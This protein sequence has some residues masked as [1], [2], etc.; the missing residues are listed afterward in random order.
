MKNCEYDHALTFP[1]NQV[2]IINDID[3]R[4]KLIQI[5]GEQ[6]ENIDIFLTYF[7]VFYRYKLF[8]KFFFNPK[9]TEILIKT[10]T[11]NRELFNNFTTSV[12]TPQLIIEDVSINELTNLMSFLIL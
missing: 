9:Y 3:I 1:K 2:D 6:A 8:L 10:L 12:I 11:S 4:E 5:T 7:Y